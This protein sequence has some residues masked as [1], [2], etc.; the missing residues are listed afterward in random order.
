[1][2]QELFRIPGTEIA[3]NGFSVALIVGFLCASQ[4]AKVLARRTGINPEIILNAGMIALLTGIVGAR[5][6]HVFENLSDY[7]D[8]TRSAWA[9]FTDA[10]NIR[11]G[12]LTYYGG[13]L[14]GVPCTMAYGLWKRVPIRHGMDLMAPA[15]LV[16]LAFGRIG[17]FLNGCCYGAQ[18]DLPWAVDFPYYS[19]AYV[20]QYN[21]EQLDAPDPLKFRTDDGRF[22]LTPPDLLEPDPLKRELARQQ[23]AL[24]VHPAQLYSAFTAFLL[25]AVLVALFTLPHAQ[26]SL[27]ML[28]LV[29]E[30]ASRFVLELL[31]AEPSVAESAWGG[32]SFSMIISLALVAAGIVGWL[33]VRRMPPRKDVLSYQPADDADKQHARGLATRV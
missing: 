25:A 8:P 11:S 10:I 18:C 16:G 13:F 5:A 28:M 1:M 14:L 15:L 33:V 24:P 17:C 19:T 23:H 31:R 27:F 26:G 2:L 9:N 3:I 30:G 4:L 20:D 12:G 6:S 32:L 29:L 22:V 7:T 21:A